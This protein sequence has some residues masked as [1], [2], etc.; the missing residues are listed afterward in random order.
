MITVS[1]TPVFFS[2][3]RRDAYAIQLGFAN[4]TVL[5]EGFIS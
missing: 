4:V 5:S 3:A 1:G 2:K